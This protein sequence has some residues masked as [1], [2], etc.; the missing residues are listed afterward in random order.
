MKRDLKIKTLEEVGQQI[1]QLI[2]AARQAP[3]AA[4]DPQSERRL[5]QALALLWAAADTLDAPRVG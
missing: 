4:G 3:A 2:G 5:N 1:R